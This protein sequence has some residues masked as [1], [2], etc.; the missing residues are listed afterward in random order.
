MTVTRQ[1]RILFPGILL[2]LTWIIVNWSTLVGMIN[3][4]MNSNT[5]TYGFLIAPISLYLIWE[6]K[7]LLKS[8]I[9]S[10]FWLPVIGLFCAQT[11]WLVGRLAGINLIEQLA[12]FVSI[13]AIV[14]FV[15]GWNYYR[16]ILFPM[17]YLIFCVPMGAELVPQL[18]QI[19][20]DLCVFLL[21]VFG[22]PVYR[23]GLYLFIPNGIFEVA[24]ACA[25]IRFLIASVALGTMFA[26]MFYQSWW[27]R[28]L[29]FVVCIIV[30]ILANGFRAF[31]IVYLGYVSDMT[32]AVGADHLVYGWGFFMLVIVILFFIGQLWQD[33]FEPDVL[34]PQLNDIASP[35][36]KTTML[37]VGIILGLLILPTIFISYL[38]QSHQSTNERLPYSLLS[39]R[40]ESVETLRWQPHFPN[41]HSTFMGKMHWHNISVQVYIADYRFDAD[42]S[43]L[44]QTDNR[45]FNIDTYSY[46]APSL[47]DFNDSGEKVELSELI[48]INANNLNKV[49]WYQ[50]G[51]KRFVSS[52]DVKLEQLK[53]KLLGGQGA[54]RYIAI[55]FPLN[56]LSHDEIGQLVAELE[57]VLTSVADAHGIE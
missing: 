42:E 9:G 54:G 20:A 5:Y 2:G 33:K 37:K 25:G 52:S 45:T 18:Q 4:W 48:S 32:V 46:N 36:N 16:L 22:V 31:G 15:L 28:S 55:A 38:S 23:D 41:A 57:G 19:T 11:L 13:N 7:H 43:E 12:I 3:V 24:E 6:K 30:P 29:F 34:A 56:S 51:N 8:T 47:I 1:N 21:N 14:W 40:F 44:I 10:S 27:K 49:G 35:I 50:V 26:Y 39:Q 17:M 53:D